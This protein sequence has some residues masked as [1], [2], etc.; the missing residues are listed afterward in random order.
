ML[1]VIIFNYDG[2][3]GA[4]HLP[5]CQGSNSLSLLTESGFK[6]GMFLLSSGYQVSLT[7]SCVG[8]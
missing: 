5:A 3:P 2:A 1:T 8:F 6:M 4:V 7:A